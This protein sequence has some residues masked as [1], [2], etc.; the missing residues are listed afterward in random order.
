M[1]AKG[2]PGHDAVRVDKTVSGAE[3]APNDIVRAEL[4]NNSDDVLSFQELNRLQAGRYLALI[5]GPQISHMP[6]VG[7]HQQI[8]LRPVSGGM[9]HNLFKIAE[10]RD[11]I[12][13]HADAD[14]SGKLGAHASHAFPGR[15]FS[16]MALTFENQD[17]TAS[18]FGELIGD[19]RPNDTASHDDYVRR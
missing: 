10:E 8:S 16:L 9:P 11:R 15:T 18:S 3:R 13:R 14:V 19:A 7:G 2:E 5:V 4:R 12:K 6:V 1:R 17:I